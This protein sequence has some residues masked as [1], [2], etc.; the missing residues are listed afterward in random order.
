MRYI[1]NEY[2]QKHPDFGEFTEEKGCSILSITEDILKDD[3]L[4]MYTFFDRYE[5]IFAYFDDWVLIKTNEDDTEITDIIVKKRA[6]T[7]IETC[8]W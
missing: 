3:L 8:E 1:L 5:K 4:S 7:H 2:A 6:K